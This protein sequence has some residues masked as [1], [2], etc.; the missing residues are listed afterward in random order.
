M[1]LQF[2]TPAIKNLVPPRIVGEAKVGASLDLNYGSW[3]P[4]LRF[5]K[6][7]WYVFESGRYVPIKFNGYRLH[8]TSK[9][10]GKKVLAGVIA[11]AGQTTCGWVVTKPVKVR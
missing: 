6:M 9:L 7:Q 4:V 3:R 2:N 10:K 1:N 8:L 5:A 11:C